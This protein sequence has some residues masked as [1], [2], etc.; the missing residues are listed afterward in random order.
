MLQE[1]AWLVSLAG[2]AFLAAAFLFVFFRSGDPAEYGPI[3][4]RFY[5]FRAVWFWALVIVGGWLSAETLGHL[6]YAATHGEA[7]EE[8][9]KVDVTGY[10]WYWKMSRNQF[11]AERTVEFRVTSADVNHSFA[12]YNADDEV[13]AQTQAMP[14]YTNKLRHTFDKPGTYKV[15]CLEYCG[16]AHHQM[17]H[18]LKVTA[19]NGGQEAQDE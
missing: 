2:I 12:I 11:P 18:T 6:P 10:Q 19:P 5:R 16:L 8:A 7:N 1:L 13:V 15:M 17:K 14:D 3:Q 9:L 4:K